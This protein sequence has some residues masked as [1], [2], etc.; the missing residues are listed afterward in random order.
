MTVH[1][2]HPRLPVSKRPTVSDPV[3]QGDNVAASLSEIDGLIRL[4]RCTADSAAC[5]DENAAVDRSEFTETL[6][7][8]HGK[9]RGECDRLFSLL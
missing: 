2:L 3:L 9:L 7:F 4:L 5:D 8:L 6:Y 1:T